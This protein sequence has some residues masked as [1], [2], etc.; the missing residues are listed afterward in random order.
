MIVLQYFLEKM[1]IFA[2]HMNKWACGT[3]RHVDNEGDDID[4]SY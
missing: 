2:P 4:V 1:E 3:H